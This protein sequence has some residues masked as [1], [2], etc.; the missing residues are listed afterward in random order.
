LGLSTT[1]RA[2]V[3]KFS[4]A[5]I[6]DVLHLVSHIWLRAAAAASFSVVVVVG[7]SDMVLSPY[8]SVSIGGSGG[9]RL[10]WSCFVSVACLCLRSGL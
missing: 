8:S 10:P 5:S 1:A 2:A 9:L 6:R 4:L 3:V 7:V